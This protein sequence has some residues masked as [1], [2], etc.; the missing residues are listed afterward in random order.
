[1]RV[2]YFLFF[3][4][5]LLLLGCT[6]CSSSSDIY[7]YYAGGEAYESM[8]KE[9]D[10]KIKDLNLG[11]RGY[12]YTTKFGKSI[13]PGS[14]IA[15]VSSALIGLCI[16]LLIRKQKAIKKT[17]IFTLIIGIPLFLFVLQIMIGF[18]AAAFRLM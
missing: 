4:M 1:M 2:R 3:F 16:L 14:I 10:E 13:L 5:F 7:N 11:E 18:I 8:F 12:Y 15:G 6:G 17:A 9:P